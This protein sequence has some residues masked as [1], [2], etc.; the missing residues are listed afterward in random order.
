MS[1]WLEV[2]AENRKAATILMLQSLHRCNISRAYYAV[3]ARVTHALLSISVSMPRSMEGP[4]HKK[5]RPLVETHLRNLDEDQRQA[6]SGIITK[7]YNMRCEADYTVS[8]AIGAAQSR[9]AMT[10]MTKALNLL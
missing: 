7:L 8:K 4:S 2:A 6:L 10:L 5:L 1:S 3:Y 9:T